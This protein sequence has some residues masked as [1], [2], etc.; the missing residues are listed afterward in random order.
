ML[1]SPVSSLAENSPFLN[2]LAMFGARWLDVYMDLK[3]L[4]IM[5]DRTTNHGCFVSAFS[6][7]SC[8]L[9]YVFTIKCLQ[10]NI[11][12]RKRTR[13]KTLCI[14]SSTDGLKGIV[15]SKPT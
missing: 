6:D 7:T 8:K 15:W 2:L 4:T 12:L 11:G 3:I 1:P 13:T 10:N 5:K 9:H 14:V